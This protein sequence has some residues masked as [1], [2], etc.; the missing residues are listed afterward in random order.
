MSD[1]RPLLGALLMLIGSAASALSAGDLASL[2][3]VLSAHQRN[4]LNSAVAELAERDT[5]RVV[6]LRSTLKLAPETISARVHGDE[7]ETAPREV[8]FSAIPGTR[9]WRADLPPLAPGSYRVTLELLR[10]DQ[11]IELVQKMPLSDATRLVEWTLQ[12]T[13]LG[14]VDIDSS[15]W[16]QQSP[17]WWATAVDWVVPDGA[18]QRVLA[19]HPRQR[20]D[21]L[22][23]RA[24]CQVGRLEGL[25][26]MLHSLR[27]VTLEADLVEDFLAC[28]AQLDQ[29]ALA[30]QV[31]QAWPEGELSSRSWTLLLDML[32]RDIARGHGQRAMTVLLQ[33]VPVQQSALQEARWRDLLSRLMLARGE[34]DRARSYL[35]EGPHMQADQTLV[36]DAD[37]QLLFQAMRLNLAI[38]LLNGG[39]RDE[40]LDLLDQIGRVT[41]SS[42]AVAALRDRANVLLGWQFLKANQ[43]LTAQAVFNR[44]DLHGE[45]AATALLGRGYALLAPPGAGQIRA[46]SAQAHEDGSLAAEPA[47]TLAAK[48]R[49]GFISCAQYQQASGDDSVCTRQRVFDQVGVNYSEDERRQRAMQSWLLVAE[50]QGHDLATQEARLRAAAALIQAGRA[51]AAQAILERAIAVLEQRRVASAQDVR[52]LGQQVQAE[53]IDV[54]QMLLRLSQGQAVS[55]LSADALARWLAQESTQALFEMR[56]T[57]RALAMSEQIQQVNQL[58]LD[59]FAEVSQ[60]LDAAQ[61]RIETEI[62]M[63]LARLYHRAAVGG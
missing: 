11:R 27:A 4:A 37:L 12:D 14:G 20:P 42:V 29:R 10:Q 8:R 17:G 54:E 16:L 58:L 24:Q 46:E 32:R 59:G 47:S 5:S 22:A 41:P 50:R 3:Q 44:V 34:Q 53:S 23:A 18:R 2:D 7:A 15:H 43:G 62:R 33:R 48:Y 63:H 36:G 13:L 49:G 38:S 61:G 9:Q 25:A 51:D 45:A 40:A 26:G 21:Y 52:W 31:L 28:S 1:H 35:R 57:A 19:R 6:Y 55:P 56:A 30:Y 39:Q 60:G